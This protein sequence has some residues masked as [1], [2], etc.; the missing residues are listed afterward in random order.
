M[1]V[2]FR[3]TIRVLLVHVG[4]WIDFCDSAGYVPKSHV[5]IFASTKLIGV[6]LPWRQRLLQSRL[7]LKCFLAWGDGVG[8]AGGWVA[9]VGW[10]SRFC[11]FSE[12][13]T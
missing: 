4:T 5:M 10:G 3:K 13:N 6:W 8:G 9:G 7:G 1:Q 12:K 11:L 2:R